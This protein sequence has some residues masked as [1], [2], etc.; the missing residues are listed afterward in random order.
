MTNQSN[1]GSFTL[2]V[3]FRA[4]SA[5][6]AMERAAIYTEALGVLR[7]EVR[8]LS[9]SLSPSASWHAHRLIFC[10]CVGPDGEECT[11]ITEHPGVHRAAGIGAPSWAG[12]GS[13]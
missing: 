6:E 11:Q 7:P 3:T 1:Q 9:T 8:L 4:S 13:R 12:E 2:H 10:G 5:V